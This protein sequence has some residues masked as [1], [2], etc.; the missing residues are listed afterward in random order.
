MG[1]TNVLDKDEMRKAVGEFIDDLFTKDETV[2]VDETKESKI[3]KSE[4]TEMS[5][6]KS[7]K[8]CDNDNDDDE[9]MKN[10]DDDMDKASKK[11]YRKGFLDAMKQMKDKDSKKKEEHT[12]D[13]K[14]SIS[15]INESSE[16]VSS[17]QKTISALTSKLE[18]IQDTVQKIAKSPASVRK[19][20]RSVD[21]MQKSRFDGQDVDID[22]TKEN[23]QNDAVRFLKSKEGRQK[24]ADIMFED[25]VLK[26]K[27]STRE[28]AE[29][30]ACGSISNPKTQRIV[31][32][33]I[34]DRL[35][36]GM[37]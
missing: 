28:I 36:G 20:V 13:V 22:E 27:L 32:S 5:K 31:K 30:E 24:I 37:F 16:E 19:S 10:C 1:D 6:T 8:E 23:S 14:K 12:E 17:L 35:D 9:F 33:L 3:E 26:G 11:I 15:V 2:S 21:I 18:S 4:T 34:N 7:E 29:Y 25:G